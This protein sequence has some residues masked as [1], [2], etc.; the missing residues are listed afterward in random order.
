MRQ[1]E[2][3][4]PEDLAADPRNTRTHSEAQ[5]AQVVASI[6]AFG[7]TNPVLIGPDNVV[8]AGHARLAAALALKLP[9]IPVIVLDHLSPAQRRAYVIA[10]NKLALN[11]GWDDELLRQ[12]LLE[13]RDDDFDLDV[14]GFDDLEL[15]A[16]FNPPNAGA[17]DPDDVPEPPAIPATRAGDVWALGSHR[18][19]CGDCTDA[20][21]VDAVLAGAKPHLMVTDPPYGVNYDANWRNE[22]GI[23]EDGSLQRLKTGRVRKSIGAKAVGKVQNDDRTDWREAWT[24]FGGDVAY[25]WHADR[26]AT[27]VDLSLRA[28]GF[29]MRAQIIWDKERMIIGRGDYHF[30]HE[31]CWYAVRKGKPGRWHGDRKQTTIWRVPHRASE[32]GHSTQKPV[33]CMRR[34]IENNSAPGD[35][36]Y[37]PFA[38]SG[39]T[40]I[41]AEMLGRHA[42]AIELHPPYVDVCVERWQN[43]TGQTATL[44]GDGRTFAGIRDARALMAAE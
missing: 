9:E 36:V 8:I 34:P 38:G 7:F 37:E 1:I 41:A 14:L 2:P 13:L 18:L 40:I 23:A 39:T 24:L 44:E 19:I 35:A 10:D 28:A 43:F 21:V 15:D 30:A 26:R 12:E 27:D 6:E 29:E 33:E 25:V 16:I 42:L 4:R 31:P 22:T 32:T 3:R 20:E 11:A 17:T 5:V